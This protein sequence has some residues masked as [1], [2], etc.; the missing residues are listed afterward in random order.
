MTI[1]LFA[2]YLFA[3]LTCVSGAVTIAAVVL[4]NFNTW[5]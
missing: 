1:Q 3:T 5:L 2:F 4:D